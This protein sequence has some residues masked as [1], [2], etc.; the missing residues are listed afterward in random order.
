MGDARPKNQHFQLGL[1]FVLSYNQIKLDGC[2]PQL[3]PHDVHN[4]GEG[5]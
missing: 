2:P 3:P 1:G 5:R 4:G